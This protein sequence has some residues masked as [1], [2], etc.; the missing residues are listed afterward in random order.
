MVSSG[1]VSRR[2][3]S[4]RT[5]SGRAVFRRGVTL[6]G[7]ITRRGRAALSECAAVSDRTLSRAAVAVLS[8]TGSPVL[9]G[10]F[11]TSPPGV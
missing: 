11:V 2:T 10:A 5:L 1:K 4:R 9:A 6:S 7:A 3:L 8:I